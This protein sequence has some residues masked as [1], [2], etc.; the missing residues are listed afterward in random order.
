MQL[1]VIGLGTMGANLARNAAR[2][3]AKVAVYNRTKDKTDVFMKRYGSDGDFVSC[4]TLKEL[5]KALKP[6]RPILIMVSAGKPVDAVIADVLPYLSKGDILI[7]GGNSHYTDTERR[8]ES[9]NTRH[10]RYLGMGVSGGEEGALNGPSMMPGGDRSAYEE[11]RPLILKMAARVEGLEGL[12]VEDD[13]G[14]RCV[15]FMGTGGAGHF[16]K[17]VHNGIEYALMQLIAESYDLLKSEAGKSNEELAEIFASWNEG[18][19]LHSFLMEIT[20]KIFMKKDDLFSPD[21]APK[22]QN[23]TTSYLIDLIKD[24]AGQKGTGKWT[25]EAAME[26]GVAIPTINAAV[27]ARIM[28][29]A[30]QQRN[31]AKASPEVIEQSYPHPEELVSRV[32]VALELSSVCA[33]LQGFGLMQV[34]TA[35]NGWGLPF[36]DIARIWRGGCIIRSSFLKVIQ[37]TYETG[38]RSAIFSRFEGEKQLHWRKVVALGVERGTPLPAMGTALAWYDTH[39]RMKL[40]TNLIQAQRDFFGAHTYERTDQEGVFHTEWQS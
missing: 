25:T 34:A 17:M 39:R 21:E 24:V 6:P 7:D 20:A 37:G 2:N 8:E 11:I 22:G 19:D 38:D 13:E 10:I 36:A 4:G 23:R 14:G 35:H 15:A 27:D 1:G 12:K 40:P 3:G 31:L 16:V 30:W 32:R 29:G 28:S 33:Y 5:A 9:L 26:L 18:D